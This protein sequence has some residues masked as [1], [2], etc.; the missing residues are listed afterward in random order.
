V[1][2][3]AEPRVLSSLSIAAV[4]PRVTA[5]AGTVEGESVTVLDAQP[6]PH[7][8]GYTITPGSLLPLRAPVG[9]VYVAWSPPAT[10]ES[11]LE[12]A[13]PPL[14]PQRREALME[15]LA[16]VRRRGW[17]ATIR[18]HG[19]A[20]T[21]RGSTGEATDRDLR[22][23]RLEGIGASAPV[24]DARGDFACSIALA[25]FPD[26]MSGETLHTIAVALDETARHLTAVLSADR[27]N[28]RQAS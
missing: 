12:R 19:P 9:T 11:W 2:R 16:L 6:G 20:T 23:Q 8:L 10:V 21:R 28:P 1:P 27:N 7:P 24:W 26:E 3:L 15:D 17:S 5:M 14:S 25:A 22:S 13:V 18:R 4:F